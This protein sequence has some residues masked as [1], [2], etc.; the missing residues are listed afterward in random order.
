MM[1]GSLFRRGLI[2]NPFIQALPFA[3][4]AIILLPDIYQKFHTSVIPN[5]INN[6]IEYIEKFIDLDNDG[7]SELIILH[8]NIN[9]IPPLPHISVFS[10]T[11]TP[12]YDIWL[13]GQWITSGNLFHV[14]YDNDESEELVIFTINNDSVFV[15]LFEIDA[16]DSIFT[17][18]CFIDRVE[19]FR[20]GYDISISHIGNS[21]LTGDGHDEFIFI[22]MSGYSQKHR[23]V[24]AWDIK[25]NCLIRSPEFGMALDLS[26]HYLVDLDND[27]F[28]EIIL[29]SYSNKYYAN[30][31]TVNDPI[32]YPD[33]SSYLIV[34][35]HNLNFLFEPKAIFCYKMYVA[36]IKLDSTIVIASLELVEEKLTFSQLINLYNTEGILIGTNKIEQ[37]GSRH[38]RLF[39]DGNE[40]NDEFFILLPNEGVIKCYNSGL[41]LRNNW[42]IDQANLL[43]HKP[44][45]IDNDGLN[46]YF[47]KKYSN[48][49]QVSNYIIASNNFSD[50]ISISINN[51]QDEEFLISITN[52]KVNGLNESFLLQLSLENSYI[53]Q[54]KKNPKYK[55][56]IVIW[57]LIYSILVSFI[58]LIQWSQ[59]IKTNNRLKSEKELSMYQLRA[60]KNQIDPHFTLNT[61]NAIS[62]LYGTGQD[63]EAYKYMTKL[64]RLMLLVLN[65]SD[66]IGTTLKAEMEM[67]ENYIE[68]QQI[69]FK[70]VF[71]YSINWD[72]KKLSQ[73]EVPRMLIHFFTENA[74]KHGLRLKGKNG[75]L[76][77]DINER[78]KYL[79]IVIEDNG[80][81]RK[82]AKQDKSF[83]SGKGLEIAYK[84]CKLYKNLSGV[85]VSFNIIDLIDENV[86]A[87]TRVAI[88]VHPRLFTL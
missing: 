41:E 30:T 48:S 40:I 81:G 50:Q 53:C 69:R 84:I 29:N 52:K 1:F 67:I 35:D 20:Q 87:G 55:Y 45:D 88:T 3:I 7:N 59:R 8:N 27:G 34:L 23:G 77:I 36:P 38:D 51:I 12:K 21:D 24:Y 86:P 75:I 60:I 14:D 5:S 22:F 49:D 2:L 85:K 62:S 70:N 76:K 44:I 43:V 32:P 72:S 39:I 16:L 58:A 79:R 57:I 42:K 25:N 66:Q 37:K 78:E 71:E 31:K 26:Q 9:V 74:I 61:L 83:S 17:V 6:N 19:K 28:E 15:N 68:L 54:Y 33:T 4:I 80:V 82:A 73:R 47:F 63:K 13:S 11:N 10:A 46:E 18:V 56:R 65:N 64:S